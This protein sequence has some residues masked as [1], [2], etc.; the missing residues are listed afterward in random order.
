ML[1]QVE[2]GQVLVSMVGCAGRVAESNGVHR[3]A[4]TGDSVALCI[5]ISTSY[6][7]ARDVRLFAYYHEFMPIHP[8]LGIKHTALPHL[9]PSPSRAPH[10]NHPTISAF[11]I[12]IDD[13][14][15]E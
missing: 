6:L 4:V 8:C 15:I 5:A 7:Q 9:T 10:S 12:E 2:E 1:S 3:S 11:T 14:N 13:N